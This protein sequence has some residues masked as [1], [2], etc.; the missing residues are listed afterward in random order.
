MIVDPVQSA[1]QISRGSRHVP[2]LSHFSHAERKELLILY[3]IR[4]TIY[5]LHRRIKKSGKSRNWG[6]RRRG[7]SLKLSERSFRIAD[8]HPPL[9]PGDFSAI[10]NVKKYL[11]H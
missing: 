7:Q 11:Y 4:N 3:D 2:R 6:L 5:T 1:V 10:S 8:A 9:E